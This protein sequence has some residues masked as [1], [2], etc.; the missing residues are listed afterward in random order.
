VF[1]AK[2]NFKDYVPQLL[3]CF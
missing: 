2:I 3:S 1:T